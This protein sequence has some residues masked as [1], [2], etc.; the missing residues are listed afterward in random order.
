MKVAIQGECLV[1]LWKGA[2]LQEAL[3][4]PAYLPYVFVPK[5]PQSFGPPGLNMILPFFFF[6]LCVRLPASAASHSG[7]QATFFVCCFAF[8]CSSSDALPGYALHASTV[9]SQ[10]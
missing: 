6:L 9:R 8:R 3:P 1:A 5:K 4:L 7:I 10:T 2:S